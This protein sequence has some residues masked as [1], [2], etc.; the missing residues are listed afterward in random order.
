M[1]WIEIIT[2][3]L[4]SPVDVPLIRALRASVKRTPD[5]SL[6]RIEL[7]YNFE[8]DNDLAV[9]LVHESAIG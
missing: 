3:R 8:M 7:F 9:H 4:A 6:R 5:D 1:R 2:A